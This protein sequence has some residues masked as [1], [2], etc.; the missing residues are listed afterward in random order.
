M[1]YKEGIYIYSPTYNRRSN[2]LNLLS[3]SEKPKQYISESILHY[4]LQNSGNKTDMNSK[5]LFY[6]HKTKRKF[7]FFGW[8][9]PNVYAER[10]ENTGIVKWLND[11]RKAEEPD[12]RA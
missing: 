9:E 11:A 10:L 1:A 8:S 12:L 3:A 6:I 4:D 5:I 7:S 2:Q